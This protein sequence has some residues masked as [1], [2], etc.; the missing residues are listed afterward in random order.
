MKAPLMCGIAGYW[1]SGKL[2]PALLIRMAQC[3]AHRGP[4][5]HGTWSDSAAGI[6][7][8]HRRLA[9]VD[10][11]P[12]G[13]QPMT[14]SDGRWV[15][16]FNGEIYNHSELRA[17]LDSTGKAPRGGWRGHSDTEV[18]VETIATEG[19]EAA[20]KETV[21]MFA[22]VLWDRKERVLRLARDRF[23]EKPLYYGWAGTDFIFA[24][25]LKAL[26][27]HRHFDN[28]I[29]RRGLKL[30]AAYTYIP[31]PIS[32]YKRIFK[33]LP[34]CILTLTMEAAARPLSDPPEVAKTYDGLCLARYWSYRD[35]VLGGL[36]RPIVDEA[37]ALD[38]LESTLARAIKD[39]SVADVP[40]GAFLSGGIDSSTIVA[41][42]QKYSS[43]PVRT[44]SIGFDEAGFNEAEHAKAIARQL[45]TV[46]AEHYVTVRE[47]REV[48]PL[49][50]D[51]Y[52]E[53]FGDSSQVPTF[54]VSRFAREQVTVAL[55]GDGGDELFAGYIR[56]FAAPR[57]WQCVHRVPKSLRSTAASPLA[58]VPSQ[59]WNRLGRLAPGRRQP[60]FG[61]KL[62]KAFRVAG[63]AN[64]F[65]DLYRSFL[66]EWSFEESPVLGSEQV[67][68]Y[69][70]LQLGKRAPDALRM[71]YCDALRY[72]PDDILAKVDRASMAVSLETRVP[73]LDHRVAELAAR[74]PLNLKVRDGK[75][76]YILRE[77]LC[78]LVPK[79]LVDRPK[80]G[81]GIAVGDWIKGPLRP[82]AEDLLD[83]R[84]MREEGWFDP[85]IVH[86]RWQA[87]LT[88]RRDSTSAIWAILMFQA[89]LR[90][91]S[92]IVSPAA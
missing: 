71:M 45:G 46:H 90:Q 10:L 83:Q 2:D 7:L 65:D 53:P 28:R 60:H 17:K 31:A 29:S 38:A 55:T 4:D 62:Q 64:T 59:V 77:L 40:V 33:L 20:L 58:R 19:L 81:F 84:R 54:L 12:S 51:I 73:Y 32:I 37:D 70:E 25:E 47:A 18:L 43:S 11:S 26:R 14:S 68:N 34:G 6:G 87:H 88:G 13:H 23:G 61:S 30:F 57:L 48:I 3:L 66:D 78:G 1:T 8:A 92:E 80:A 67:N 41:L 56:H 42:Y 86:H 89:W 49:L 21:G 91:Q 63:E 15:I 16:I 72:L 44:F 52:D 39:Q 22:I 82:W 5:D 35:V 27:V 9:I 79:Q 69:F 74:I 50:P 85:A 75:G 24:S 36:E 76:K